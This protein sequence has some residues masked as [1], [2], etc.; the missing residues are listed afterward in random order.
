MR[1][2]KGFLEGFG[3]RVRGGLCGSEF[4]VSDLA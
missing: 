1:A 4:K 3:V 2:R